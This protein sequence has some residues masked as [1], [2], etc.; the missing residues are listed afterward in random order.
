MANA[1]ITLPA[2]CDRPAAD[3][4]LPDLRAAVATGEV[5]ID[6]NHVVQLGQAVLQLLLSARETLSARGIG[7]SVTASPAMRATLELVDAAQLIN[8]GHNQ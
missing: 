4:L 6:G 8:G 7:M 5:A 3:A 1:T 2:R